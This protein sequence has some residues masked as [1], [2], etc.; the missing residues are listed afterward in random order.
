MYLTVVIYISQ[1][2]KTVGRTC[3]SSLCVY[4][5]FNIHVCICEYHYCTYSKNVWITDRIKLTLFREG[6]HCSFGGYIPRYVANIPNNTTKYNEV[7]Y[8]G[9]SV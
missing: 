8:F 2:D 4:T 5:N 1:G 3:S 6:A 9:H 7:F